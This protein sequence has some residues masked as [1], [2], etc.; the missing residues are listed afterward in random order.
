[1]QLIAD[2]SVG[3]IQPDVARAGGITETWRIAELAQ[4][5]GIAYAPHVGWSGAVCVAASLQLAGAAEA[6]TT[7][8]CMVFANPLR[9]D[10]LTRPVGRLDELRDGCLPIPDA[11]GLGIE[12]DAAFIAAHRA[13]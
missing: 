11:P 13:P 5:F 3:L 2:R 7:F 8:E 9:D 6:C 4:S 12:V 10:L 1:M